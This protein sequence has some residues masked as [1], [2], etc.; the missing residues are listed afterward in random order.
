MKNTEFIEEWLRLWKQG[1]VG[2]DPLLLDMIRQKHTYGG[3]K[4]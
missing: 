1:V 4:E 3:D 2:F